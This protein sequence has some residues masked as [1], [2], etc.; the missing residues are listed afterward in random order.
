MEVDDPA[1]EL[2]PEE[3]Y[4]QL[5]KHNS[6]FSK[7]KRYHFE[8]DPRGEAKR[9]IVAIGR[10]TDI[11]NFLSRPSL[12]ITY[13]IARTILFTLEVLAILQRLEMHAEA[14]ALAAAIFPGAI[15]TETEYNKGLNWLKR[16]FPEL[17]KYWGRLQWLEASCQSSNE[18]DNVELWP[19]FILLPRKI[20]K[21]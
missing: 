21:R 11:S 9:V 14:D 3:L 1:F 20:N 17:G 2:T 12:Y 18:Y 16:Y 19:A 10:N 13:G 4:E 8:H 15:Y 6:L 5:G 7:S